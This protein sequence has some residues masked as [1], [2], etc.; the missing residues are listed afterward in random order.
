MLFGANPAACA[1]VRRQFFGAIRIIY[2]SEITR[3]IENMRIPSTL[4][5]RQGVKEQRDYPAEMANLFP[6]ILYP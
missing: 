5:R 1:C 3:L 4:E 2:V 6:L